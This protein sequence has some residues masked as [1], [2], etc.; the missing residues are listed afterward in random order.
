MY[1]AEKFF[2]KMNNHMKRRDLLWKEQN[3]QARKIIII[4]NS[5]FRLQWYFSMAAKYVLPDSL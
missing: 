1:D 2:Q 3:E 5:L 4:I